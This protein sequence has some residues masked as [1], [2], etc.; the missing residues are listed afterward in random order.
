MSVEPAA[1]D[2]KKEAAEPEYQY[3]GYRFGGI[4]EFACPCCGMS[5][6]WAMLVPCDFPAHRLYYCNRCAWGNEV[7]SR[8]R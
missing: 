6:S 4:G 8:Y 3:D 5:V 7:P 2:R 1:L